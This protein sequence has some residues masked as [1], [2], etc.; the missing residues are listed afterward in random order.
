[1][2]RAQS[3]VV[4]WQGVLTPFDR[5]DGYERRIQSDPADGGAGAASTSG[6]RR[7]A[8]A[9]RLRCV[10]ALVRVRMVHQL[11]RSLRLRNWPRRSP[12]VVLHEVSV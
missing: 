7:R 10:W 11:R 5:L 2:Q 6:G 1:V 4:C 12:A 9:Q 8:R 3:A